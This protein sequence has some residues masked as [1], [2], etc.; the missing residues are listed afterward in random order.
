MISSGQNS[1]LSNSCFEVKRAVMQRYAS[2]VGNGSV[3]SLKIFYVY[4][5]YDNWSIGNIDS[6]QQFS[7]DFLEMTY[8]NDGKEWSDFAAKQQ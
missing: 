6:H 5:K 1:S 2:G 4:S 8:K 7:I 3:E